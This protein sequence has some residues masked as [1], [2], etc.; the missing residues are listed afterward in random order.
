[1]IITILAALTA[2][3]IVGILVANNNK[4]K[5]EATLADVRNVALEYKKKS[6]DAWE[7][8][9]QKVAALK[10]EAEA[11]QNSKKKPRNG[12]KG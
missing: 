7:Y 11:V 8:A 12:S 9:E 6:E 10:A 4:K 2:G 5:V 1:M 3:F